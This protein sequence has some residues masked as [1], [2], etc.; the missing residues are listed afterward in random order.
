MVDINA[1]CLLS[2]PQ[3]SKKPPPPPQKN[4]PN[5]VDLKNKN[6]IPPCYL[7]ILDPGKTF[8][9]A[10]HLPYLLQGT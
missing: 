1:P 2:P 5:K 10:R 3:M 9:Q 7:Q 6:S 4:L 8:L